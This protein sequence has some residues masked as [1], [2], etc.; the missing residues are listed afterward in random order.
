VLPAFS[1]VRSR[2]EHRLVAARGRRARRGPLVVH[3]LVG[4]VD[5]HEP[6]RAGVVVGKRVGNAVVRNTVKRRL[7]ELLRAR[8]AAQ[9]P[10]SLIVVR[11]LPGAAQVNVATLGRALDQALLSAA[12]ETRSAAVAR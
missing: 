10:G 12:G 9:P 8:L 1:R 3:V 4:D 11:A 7:R 6:A 2:S 5:S